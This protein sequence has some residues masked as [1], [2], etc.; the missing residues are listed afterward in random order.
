MEDD[1]YIVEEI[2]DKRVAKKGKEFASISSS[3]LSMSINLSFI[4]NLSRHFVT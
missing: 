2:L 1:E 3:L 4:V